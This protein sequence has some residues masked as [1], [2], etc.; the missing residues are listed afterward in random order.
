MHAK[1]ATACLALGM[2]LPLAVVS[3][4]PLKEP[5]VEASPTTLELGKGDRIIARHAGGVASVAFSPDGKLLATAGG[6]NLVRLLDL[7]TGKEMHRLEGHSGFIRT[8]VFSPDGKLL[9]S[10][11]NGP[12]ALLWD[13]ATGKEVR[14]FGRHRNGFRLAAFSPDAK[15]LVTTAF[16]EHIG[17]W[18]LATGKELHFFRAHPRVPYCVAFL[19]DSRALVS[20]GDKEGTLRLWDVT[21]GK[22]LRHWGDEA[23]G[24]VQAVALSPDG[25]LLASTDHKSIYL[26]EMTTGK[27]V[28]RLEGHTEQVTKLAFAPDGRTL[29]SGGQDQMAC[30]WETMTG[31]EVRRFRKHGGWVWG[32]A[33]AP[34]G[35][36][37][38]TASKD[39]TAVVW[40]LGSA[41]QVPV[42][43]PTELT[44]A[45]LAGAWRDL[46]GADA[47]RA[48]QSALTLSA[49]VPRQVVPF[50]RER[51]RPAPVPRVDAARLDR[52]IRNLD[53]DEFSV[54]ENAEK[55]LEKLDEAA[56]PALRKAQANPPSLEARRRLEGLVTKL[57]TREI[58]PERLQALRALRVLEE[59]HTPE[60]REHL[61]QLAGGAPDNVLTREAATVLA[62][63]ARRQTGAP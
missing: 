60:T 20:G 25:R 12:A 21:T 33:Y 9:V 32:V 29:L 36:T 59:L 16:D 56:G 41:A 8:V 34:T 13:T 55:E 48:F 17:L 30:L 28:H 23:K 6:D 27:E 22:E 3:A 58:S 38:A 35:R 1:L 40:N 2:G 7:A 39:G 53:D 50:L 49:A 61:K 19:P 63:L 37:V 15:T 46:A 44:A 51:L 14:Q 52:L 4:E 11:G 18:D 5:P 43:R 26:W 47:G 42:R 31:K 24:D 62:R 57:D 45:E 10:A 54:R